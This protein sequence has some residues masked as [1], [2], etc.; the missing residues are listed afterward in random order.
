VLGAN[1][2]HATINLFVKYI[3]HP[4]Y[5]RGYLFFWGGGGQEMQWDKQSSV[6]HKKS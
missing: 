1:G 6:I 2:H 4:D 3:Y 5:A